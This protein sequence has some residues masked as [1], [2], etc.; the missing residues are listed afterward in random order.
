MFVGTHDE[1]IRH[2]HTR[3]DTGQVFGYFFLIAALEDEEPDR[4]WQKCDQEDSDDN[5]YRPTDE[6]YRLPA[7]LAN[8]AGRDPAGYS[9]A[10]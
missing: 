8:D 6:K 2:G 3:R 4:L 1:F 7:E 9:G 10:K 5:R